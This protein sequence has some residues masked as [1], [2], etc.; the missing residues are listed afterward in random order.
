VPRGGRRAGSPGASYQNRT[1]LNQTRTLPAQAATGQPYG[2]AGAQLAAQKAVPMGTPPV[3]GPMPTGGAPM[4]G[5]PMGDPN[6]P[7][8]PGPGELPGLTDPT[9]RPGEPV[10]HGLPFGPGGGPG[11]FP[12]APDP[13]LKG[14]ALLNTLGAN[15]PASLKAVQA[16]LA[17]SHAN[18]SAP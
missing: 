17:A 3:P 15:L 12:Q 13:V 9:N 8:P 10:T 11:I 7:P 1:D 14:M 2:A 6:T 16:S 4:G 18:A 5:A